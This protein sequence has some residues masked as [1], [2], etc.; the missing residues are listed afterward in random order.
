MGAFRPGVQGTGLAQA[1]IHFRDARAPDG[2][3]LYAIGDVHGRLD[4]LTA[5]HTQIGTDLARDGITDWR[6]IH[7]GDYVDR[8]PDSKGVLDLLVAARRRDPRTVM[9]AGN[10]DLGFLE[11]LDHPDPASLFVQY[12]GVQTAKSYGV[13]LEQDKT[14]LFRHPRKSLRTSHAEL[15]GAVPASHV[16]FLRSLAF[17][18]SFGDFFFCHA[19]IRPGIALE[20]QDARDLIWIRDVF[21]NHSGL[22]PKVIVH[23]HT[24]NEKAEIL[25]NRVNVD[26][27]A[28]R[29][30]R[31]TALVVDGARKEIL[32]VSEDGTVQRSE[33][34]T[35]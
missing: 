24:P 1:G 19:G 17:S 18:A 25:A 11:F 3:R 2:M 15:V 21:H 31:L 29:S 12:G 35:P 5:M 20:Q 32:T 22:Y 26:T 6:V 10:H 4:L 23:G 27:L 34:V 14:G 30:G 9:L 28:Y 7:L 33:A 8:G 13:D 16:E